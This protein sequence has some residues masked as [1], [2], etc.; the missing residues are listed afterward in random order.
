MRKRNRN[1]LNDKPVELDALLQ[2]G[3]RYALA[4][5]HHAAQAEDLVQEACLRLL[6]RNM[7]IE[8]PLLFKIIRNRFI[9]LY[10]HTKRFPTD[11]LSSETNVIHLDVSQTTASDEALMADGDMLAKSLGRLNMEEREAFYLWAV[12]GYTANEIAQLGSMSRNTVLSRIHRTRK[13]LRHILHQM[14]NEVAP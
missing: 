8:L 10:R 9:D 12:E 6:N 2:R 3:F 4:L 7:A 11:S 13:K 1:L 5:T 14:N